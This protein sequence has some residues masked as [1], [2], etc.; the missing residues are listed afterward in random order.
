MLGL[1]FTE[2]MQQPA[3]WVELYLLYLEGKAKA[4]KQKLK[5][6]GKKA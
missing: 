1:S 4:E 2:L 5:S 6:T 3:H